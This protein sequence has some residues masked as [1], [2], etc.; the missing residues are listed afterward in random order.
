MKFIKIFE[1]YK[2]QKELELLSTDILVALSKSIINNYKLNNKLDIN[3]MTTITHVYK[4]NKAEYI[5]ILDFIQ[6]TNIRVNLEMVDKVG[7]DKAYMRPFNYT[8]ARITVYIDKSIQ[9][10]L[11]KLIEKNGDIDYE[12]VYFEI[13]IYNSSLLHE[14]QH[15]F[16]NYR[17]KGEA[18]K[19]RTG[20]DANKRKALPLEFMSNLSSEQKDILEQV[21]KQ[22]M[23]LPFEI[24]ARFTQAIADI[25][26]ISHGKLLPWDKVYTFFKK[27]FKGWDYLNIKD[28]KRLVRRLSQFYFLEGD[29][30]SN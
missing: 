29:K 5:D 1:T 28:R 7:N 3:T 21:Y 17:S 6:N 13:Y 18:L 14:L 9:E 16:D 26:F 11:E 15:A 30:V 12:D 27:S 4:N 25:I 22:Y 24:D 2:S 23:N 19:D 10:D 8:T 20:Y